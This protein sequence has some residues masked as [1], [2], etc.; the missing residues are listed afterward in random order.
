MPEA[1]KRASRRENWLEPTI[2]ERGATI[3]A[4]ATILPGVRVGRYSMVA[5]GALVTADVPPFAL[6]IGAPARRA[7]HLCRCGQK[8]HD[9]YTVATCDYCGETPHMRCLTEELKA[10]A[11]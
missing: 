2:V 7:G 9:R 4:N 10:L 11:L 8:L 5:A 1:R 3:G 6:M